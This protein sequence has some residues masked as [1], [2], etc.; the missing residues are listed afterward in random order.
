[1][2]PT[3]V[4]VLLLAAL[5]A[6]AVPSAR[7]EPPSTPAGADARVR[8]LPYDPDRVYA[9]TGYVGYQIDLEFEPGEVFE[10][11]GAGD[12]DGLAFVAQDN[13]L[14]LKPRAARVSTNITVLTSRRH[15]Y[16]DY[17]ARPIRPGARAPAMLYSLRFSYPPAAAASSAERI[18]KSLDAAAADRLPNFDYW[19]CGDPALKPLS[20]MDDGVHTRLRFGTRS[21]MPAVFVQNDDGSESLLNYSVEDGDVLVH[22]VVRRL[23]LRRGQLAGCVV[24]RSFNGGGVR[25]ESGTV[26]PD[27]ERATRVQG[28]RHE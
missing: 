5:L 22:R 8:T 10:G 11:L 25:L 15:Y 28:S 26:A 17:V 21:E 20:A 7:G 16:F 9:L 3:S 13:H 1:M 27:V 4:A 19:Y 12:V 18:E 2:S 14:F 23:I 6:V 24:N